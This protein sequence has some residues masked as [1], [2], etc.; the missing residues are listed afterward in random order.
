MF[1]TAVLNVQK[2]GTSTLLSADM[3]RSLY[4]SY[5]FISLFTHYQQLGHSKRETPEH[6]TLCLLN[7]QINFIL[8]LTM[9]G[10]ATSVTSHIGIE[11]QILSNYI[12]FFHSK[13]NFSLSEIL[14]LIYYG[15]H[16][17]IKYHEV[18][19]IF[20]KTQKAQKH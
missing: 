6:R 13:M 11:P 16:I 3:A 19:P 2:G 20:M 4:C 14:I 1:K 8:N 7:L 5:K 18:K 15:M 9:H 17:Y 10:F 12:N